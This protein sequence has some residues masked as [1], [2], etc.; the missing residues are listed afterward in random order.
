M[1]ESI[2]KLIYYNLFMAFV[3]CDNILNDNK[4]LYFDILNYFRTKNV[5]V[6]LKNNQTNNKVVN[7]K[8][9]QT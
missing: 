5:N 2:H 1:I 7:K 9:N 8:K 4:T 6:Q 3:N